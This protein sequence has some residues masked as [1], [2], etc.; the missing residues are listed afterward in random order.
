[1]THTPILIYEEILSGNSN[2][3][4]ICKSLEISEKSLRKAITR[5]YKKGLVQYNQTD[6]IYELKQNRMIGD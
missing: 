6:N 3:D 5:L 2:P 1:M 4:Q